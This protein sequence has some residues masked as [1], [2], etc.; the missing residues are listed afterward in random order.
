MYLKLDYMDYRY[1]DVC[2]EIIIEMCKN[3][4]I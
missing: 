2:C 4:I 3:N 1:L